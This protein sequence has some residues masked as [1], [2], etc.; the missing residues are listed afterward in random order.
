MDGDG[1]SNGFATLTAPSILRSA[2]PSFKPQRVTTFAPTV[3]IMEDKRES[4]ASTMSNRSSRDYHHQHHHGGDD[5][6]LGEEEYGGYYRNSLDKSADS[7]KS[8]YVQ[9]L[10]EVKNKK[11]H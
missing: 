7:I 6:S 10:M 9:N 3:E 1:F 8:R 2:S 4:I 11:L 5:D